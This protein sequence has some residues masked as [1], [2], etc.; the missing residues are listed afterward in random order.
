MSRV[1]GKVPTVLVTD[2]GLVALWSALFVFMLAR[3][4]GM[5]RRFQGDAW[6]VTGA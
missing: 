4:F 5:G 1:N 3:L 6:L 2:A